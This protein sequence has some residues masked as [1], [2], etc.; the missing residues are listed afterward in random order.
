MR[1][2]GQDCTL[3]LLMCGRARMAQTR[4][5]GMQYRRGVPTQSAEVFAPYRY[6]DARTL[7]LPNVLSWPLKVYRGYLLRIFSTGSRP[8]QKGGSRSRRPGE[9]M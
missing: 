9:S 6:G 7:E 1:N 2:I 8:E 3:V 4:R 5:M